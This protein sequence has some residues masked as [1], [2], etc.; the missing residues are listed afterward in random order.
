MRGSPTR[1]SIIRAST[2]ERSPISD[3]TIRRS[4]IR[5]F[6]MMSSIHRKGLSHECST[7]LHHEALPQKDF[8]HKG[9]LMDTIEK[10]MNEPVRD[11]CMTN[12][13]N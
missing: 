1:G 3:P 5:G 2:I 13:G 7:G 12:A 9:L 8:H 4:T 10:M 11:R 6:L